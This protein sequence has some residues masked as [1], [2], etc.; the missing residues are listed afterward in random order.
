MRVLAA[1]TC[2]TCL[3]CEDFRAGN[4]GVGGYALACMQA[5]K[6]H[7]YD[8]NMPLSC[9]NV[10]L[11]GFEPLTS[12]MP[13]KSL[14]FRN[15]AGCGST[16]SFNPLYVA[17][18]SPV[19]SLACSPS[20]SPSCSPG[21]PRASRAHCQPAVAVLF[22]SPIVLK[23]FIWPAAAATA[24]AA[25]ASTL[26]PRSAQRDYACRRPAAARARPPA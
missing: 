9:E 18:R 25:T 10:E 1:T 12:C 14:L 20:C 13:Y 8:R 15:V 4:L 23:L 24:T 22:E 21:G 3:S 2:G 6:D 26:G 11:R 19:S 17:H 16:S 5:V 7:L